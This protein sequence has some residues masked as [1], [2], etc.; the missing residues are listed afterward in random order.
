M[1]D[2]VFHVE[3]H[4]C[5]LM[6]ELG[7]A[8]GLLREVGVGQ[9]IAVPVHA[10]EGCD[11]IGKR[12]VGC[13]FIVLGVIALDRVSGSLERHCDDGET[14]VEPLCKLGDGFG[15]V[16]HLDIEFFEV[17]LERR[18]GIHKLRERAGE[19]ERF[20]HVLGVLSVVVGPLY[21]GSRIAYGTLTGI[22]K[23]AA[24]LKSTALNNEQGEI[25]QQRRSRR[26]LRRRR[27]L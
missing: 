12:G 1:A 19:V 5:W 13:A 8:E 26:R 27:T 9:G 11:E 16:F 22:G 25:W 6:A 21:S 4:R 2:S 10:E 15:R 24:T 20:C 7:R 3:E 17:F 23:S 18:M 14:D